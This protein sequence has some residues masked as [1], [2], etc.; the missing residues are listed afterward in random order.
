MATYYGGFNITE[1]VTVLLI[2]FVTM[3]IYMVGPVLI[4]YGSTKDCS[5]DPYEDIC[6]QS[7]KDVL[8]AGIFVTIFVFMTASLLKYTKVL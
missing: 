6:S 8:T 3:G 1:L 4:T 2:I 5:S 7:K